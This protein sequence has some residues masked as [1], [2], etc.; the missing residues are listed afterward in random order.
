MPLQAQNVL[1]ARKAEHRPQPQV[2]FTPISSDSPVLTDS[3]PTRGVDIDPEF[4]RGSSSADDEHIRSDF[5]F[6]PQ[7]YMAQYGLQRRKALYK[8]W[9]IQIAVFAL[10]VGS[11]VAVPHHQRRVQNRENKE[12][13]DWVAGDV[14]GF[15]LALLLPAL[16]VLCYMWYLQ[17]CY[18]TSTAVRIQKLNRKIC[19]RDYEQQL[20]ACRPSVVFTATC[21]HY[22]SRIRY[23]RGEKKLYRLS[24]VTHQAKKVFRFNDVDWHDESPEFAGT[25][26]FLLTSL[27]LKKDLSLTEAARERFF[28]EFNTF[29]KKNH[30]DVNQD[31]CRVLDIQGFKENQT[32]FSISR[33]P[34]WW[35]S[36]AVYWVTAILL[37]NVPFRMFLDSRT[38]I[39]RHRVVKHVAA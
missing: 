12:T 23:E 35:V 24:V 26:D 33:P 1:H 34:P 17:Q 36:A 4:A 13:S 19:V 16:Y 32:F 38:R 8:A 39:V 2:P 31:F 11:I 22:E 3:V 27:L 15:L 37:V 10:M 29:C 25:D 14:P 28:R 7:D 18:N 30:F 9:F 6:A 21:Y 5:V 20:R